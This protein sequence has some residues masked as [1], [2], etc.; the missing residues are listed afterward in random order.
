MLRINDNKVVREMLPGTDNKVVWGMLC[1]TDN[2]VV[3]SGTITKL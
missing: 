2:N 3:K 1:R